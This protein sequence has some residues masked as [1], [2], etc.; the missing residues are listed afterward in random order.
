MSISV[1]QAARKWIL[2]TFSRLPDRRSRTGCLEFRILVTHAAIMA[3]V[4]ARSDAASRR[5]SA[6][7]LPLIRAAS[8]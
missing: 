8:H 7:S 2:L 6:A 3:D 4:S 5:S 1:Q